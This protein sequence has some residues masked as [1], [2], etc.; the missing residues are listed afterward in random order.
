MIG[1]NV[2]DNVVN[3]QTDAV[4]TTTDRKDYYT[5]AAGMYNQIGNI[6]LDPNAYKAYM[7]PF[8]DE[9]INR[10]GADMLRQQQEAQNLLGAQAQA[11]GAFGGSRFGVQSGVQ[12]GEYDRNFGDMAANLRMQGYDNAQNLAITDMNAKAN[13][14]ATAAQGL[15]GVGNNL[16]NVASSY[17]SMANQMFGQGI[18]GLEQQQAAAEAKRKEEQQVLDAARIQLL[19]NLGY[20]KDALTDYAGLFGGLPKDT[21]GTGGDPGLIDFILAINSL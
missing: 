8:T 18:T 15:Q 14:M 4:N 13:N 21:V 16:G 2:F 12:A 11:A 6:S 9:V 17:Q 7:N 3:L 10:T 19:L 20:G 5:D 1:D